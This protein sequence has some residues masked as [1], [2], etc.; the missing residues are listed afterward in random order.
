[1]TPFD[2]LTALRATFPTPMSDTQLG[3]LLNTVAWTHRSEG[4]VSRT[5]GSPDAVSISSKCPTAA[6][7]HSM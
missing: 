2:T 1:M 7:S 5:G 6:R 4:Y 3:E